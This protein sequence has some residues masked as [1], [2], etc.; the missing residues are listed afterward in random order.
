MAGLAYYA[1]AE[2]DEFSVTYRYGRS[3]EVLDSL[4]SVDKRTLL[5]SPELQTEP[6]LTARIALTKIVT[7]FRDRGD[8]P[9]RGS[10]F[11]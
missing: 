7:T 6:G 5:T 9:E 11:V 10:S 1:K 2:E 3:P 8:W 4:L